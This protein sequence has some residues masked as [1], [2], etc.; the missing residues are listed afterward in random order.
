[1]QKIRASRWTQTCTNVEARHSQKLGKRRT[2]CIESR[3]GVWLRTGKKGLGIGGN[4]LGGE[5]REFD[6][7]G[8]GRED[9]VGG[10][11]ILLE[12]AKGS[13]HSCKL[14]GKNSLRKGGSEA[15][16]CPRQNLGTSF[17]C[18][19]TQSCLDWGFLYSGVGPIPAEGMA[20]TGKKKGEN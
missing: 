1:M 7:W 13:P 17:S 19:K 5:K 20:N 18:L 10:G 3:T 9:L 16:A 4:A 12:S 2:F 6:A 15:A 11:I 14:K 8:R